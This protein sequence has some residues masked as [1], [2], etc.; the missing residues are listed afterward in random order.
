ML[1]TCHGHHSP[2]PLGAS[3]F[4]GIWK[5]K[6]NH[7]FDIYFLHTF[8]A[9]VWRLKSL[10]NQKIFFFIKN[11]NWFN[12]FPSQ[13]AVFFYIWYKVNQ[14]CQSKIFLD[15]LVIN[16]LLNSIVENGW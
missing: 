8:C 9:I 1:P 15:H 11:Q 4:R 12:F 13:V 10:Q 16:K 2:L 6:K 3:H 14:N 7:L 5:C